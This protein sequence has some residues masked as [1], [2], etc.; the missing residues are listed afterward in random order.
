MTDC[1]LNDCVNIQQLTRKNKFKVNYTGSKAGGDNQISTHLILICSLS[2]ARTRTRTH[3][4]TNDKAH[5]Q[6]NI[7]GGNSEK[8][9]IYMLCV[10][11]IASCV[12]HRPRVACMSMLALFVWCAVYVRGH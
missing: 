3:A 10:T 1:I 6:I 9:N 5:T 12:S 4:P 8:E 7:E 2:N 11:R